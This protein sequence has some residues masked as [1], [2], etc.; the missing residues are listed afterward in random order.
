MQLAV[1]ICAAK[2]SAGQPSRSLTSG[3]CGRWSIPSTRSS[4]LCWHAATNVASSWSSCSSDGQKTRITICK[5]TGGHMAVCQNLVPLVNIKIAGK[6][7]FIPLK[8][9]SIGIDPYPYLPDHQKVLQHFHSEFF[10]WIWSNQLGARGTFFSQRISRVDL[11]VW[12]SPP[13]FRQ[14][15]NCWWFPLLNQGFWSKIPRCLVQ[16]SIVCRIKSGVCV[17]Y[18]NDRFWINL[19]QAQGWINYEIP[20]N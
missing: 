12:S 16:G 5:P 6:W 9:V 2:R 14:R 8:M 19:L 17:A 11:P 10:V 13:T 4:S 20:L 15:G 1:P 18:T 3:F 7:M